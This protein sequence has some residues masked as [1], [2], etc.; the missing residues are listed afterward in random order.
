MDAKESAVAKSRGS[1][2]ETDMSPPDARF[3]PSALQ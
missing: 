3:T 2:D 1:Q